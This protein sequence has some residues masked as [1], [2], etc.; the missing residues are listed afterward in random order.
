MI[1]LRSF[2]SSRPST[3][4]GKSVKGITARAMV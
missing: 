3:A 2:F 1:Q 4:A